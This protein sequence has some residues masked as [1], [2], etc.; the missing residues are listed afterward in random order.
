[1]Q[2]KKGQIVDKSTI[3]KQGEFS[4]EE[5]EGLIAASD[6]EKGIYNIALQLIEN[7]VLIVDQV[8]DNQVQDRYHQ[9]TGQIQDLKKQYQEKDHM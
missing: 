1:M 2:I 6:T 8:Q 7:R 5:Y 3:L 4:K 9:L